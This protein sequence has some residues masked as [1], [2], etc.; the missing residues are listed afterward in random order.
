MEGAPSI[1][2]LY[3]SHLGLL[4]VLFRAFKIR[5]VVEFGMGEYSTEFFLSKECRLLSIEQQQE[6]W[7]NLCL[8]NYGEY[9]EWHPVLWMFPRDIG[10]LK[11]PEDIDL[12]FVDGH[13][14]SRH[15]CVNYFFHK[16][17]L[18]AAHDWE[19]TKYYSWHLVEK[20]D[21]YH[22]IEYTEYGKQTVLFIH[23]SVLLEW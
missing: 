3:S 2:E 4:K 16:A 20:P 18:I 5:K 23:D 8:I 12:V 21:D 10:E 6:H 15:R 11:F 14:G 1:E 19:K 13:Q 7:F 9:K 17:P 22:M